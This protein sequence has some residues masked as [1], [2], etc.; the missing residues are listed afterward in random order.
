MRYVTGGGDFIPCIIFV[1]KLTAYWALA[2]DRFEA[3]CFVIPGVVGIAKLLADVAGA[4]EKSAV[5]RGRG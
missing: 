2:A 3:R 1:V 4:G 5:W